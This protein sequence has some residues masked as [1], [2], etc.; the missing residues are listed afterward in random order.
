VTINPTLG[1]LDLEPFLSSGVGTAEWAGMVRI[2]VPAGGIP[3]SAMGSEPFEIRAVVTSPDGSPVDEWIVAMAAVD[4]SGDVSNAFAA[5]VGYDVTAPALSVDVPFLSA[6]W[7]FE[8]RVA[9]SAETG[10]SVRVDEGPAVVADGA[11]A[12]TIRT[13]LAPWPQTLE[14]TALDASGNATTT[15]VSIM[16]GLDIRQLPWPAI[17]AVAVIVAV[18][19][20]SIRGGR[21]AA[22]AP[23]ASAAPD[24]D[25]VPVIEDLS[26]GPTRPRD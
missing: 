8:A 7:P 21:R 20:S 1:S 5:T 9:G 16:G 3:G 23:S 19:V 12:F 26:S 18:F 10:T 17:L 6:P 25:L 15:R 11:G 2:P 14:V 13:Q 4:A 22:R 24:D